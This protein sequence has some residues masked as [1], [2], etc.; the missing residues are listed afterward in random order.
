MRLRRFVAL[1]LALSLTV[2]ALRAWDYE[3]HRI[4]N[5]LALASLPK[6]FPAFV[7][8]VANLER[9]AF[10]GGEPDR[11]RNVPDLIMKQSGGSWSDHFIDLEY[12]TDAGI[13]LATVTSFRYDF[14]V[15]YAAGRAR[16]LHNFAP[17]DPAKNA[18][19][20][21]EWPGFAPW[22]IAEQFARLR[23]GFSYLKVFE[24]LGTPDEILNA[25]A[26]ILY[27]MG[28]LGHY[29]GDCAQPLHTTRHH[30]GWAGPNP[31][32]YSTWPGLHS[33]VDGGIIAKAGIKTA[34]LTGRVVP[35]VPFSLTPRSDGREPLFVAVMDYLQASNRMVEPLYQLEKSGKLGHGEQPMTDEARM[36]VES[37][38]LEGARML[39]AIWLTAY[40]SVVPDT[41]L[42]TQLIKRQTG[43]APA[44]PRA[45]PAKKSPP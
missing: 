12:L 28:V 19:H 6:D 31:H 4:V 5:Q 24:E 13:D 9:V 42:R 27:V 18:D 33:W 41:Y 21:R 43:S 14:I 39:G 40:R 22:A 7:Q 26:N 25:Q 1:T 45:A 35:A 34:S 8:A 38:L 2:I 15:Q 17:I 44:A 32:G 30:N 16:N 36:F 11:W 20:T 3:G 29:V 37:R 23:S 10:L